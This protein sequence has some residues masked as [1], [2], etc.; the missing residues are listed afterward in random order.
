MYAKYVY[1]AG[2]T[3][4]QVL[5]DTFEIFVGETDVNNLSAGCDK[6]NSLIL[7]NWIFSFKL[8]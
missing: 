3:D 1:T 8:L 5:D 6:T 2:A 7:F 4:D